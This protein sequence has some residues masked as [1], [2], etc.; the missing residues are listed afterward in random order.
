MKKK[1]G[2][3]QP[4]LLTSEKNQVKIRLSLT[5][6]FTYERCI[7]NK[8]L[9]WFEFHSR[10]TEVNTQALRLNYVWSFFSTSSSPLTSKHL[11]P[12]NDSEKKECWRS[13]CVCWWIFFPNKVTHALRAIRT[14]F[15]LTR[16]QGDAPAVF[17]PSRLK[18]LASARPCN[19]CY[20][21]A[22]ICGCWTEVT[23]R[24]SIASSAVASEIVC[25][26]IQQKKKKIHCTWKWL[27]QEMMLYG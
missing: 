4:L 26:Y 2:E 7:T 13:G 23:P 14:C 1:I 15:M 11:F 12:W 5:A 24:K 20:G 3:S 22:S 19:W 21:T 8:V 17:F 9:I 27:F 6:I 25:E 16:H 18:P 10:K